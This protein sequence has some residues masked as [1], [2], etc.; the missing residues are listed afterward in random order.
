VA[1]AAAWREPQ[2]SADGHS[3]RQHHAIAT[4]AAALL[5]L[6]TA[7]PAPAEVGATASLLS[8]ARLRGYSLSAGRPVA[9][10]DLSYDHLN[11]L[12]A[13]LSGSVVAHDGLKP[14]ALEENVGFAKKLRGGPTLDFGI[15]NSNYSRHSGHYR[16]L[17]YTEAY[18][19]L[20]GRNVA[21]H[22]Y[23]SPNYFHSDTWTL[24]G[25]ID[26]AIQ[27]ARKWR[28]TAH[29]GALN[30]LHGAPD[31]KSQYDWRI[32][33]TREI[34]RFSAQIA[35]SGGG[36]GRDYYYGREHNRTALVAQLNC[37]F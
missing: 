32:G 20:I 5:A 25:D 21:S 1:A 4:F 37:I 14:L 27:P 9:E 33:V 26:A 15:V 17:S 12:Y 31:E 6:N 36:P 23:L 2:A 35:L 22:V 24:Y 10:L 16:S 13:G 28:V 34:G 29:V 18:A 3:A 7:T 30:Y 19:G 11:G 8:E